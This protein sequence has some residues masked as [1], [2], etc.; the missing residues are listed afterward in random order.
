MLNEFINECNSLIKEVNSFT[1]LDS[2]LNRIGY[3][4]KGRVFK[5]ETEKIITNITTIFRKSNDTQNNNNRVIQ[6]LDALHT[7]LVDKINDC[8][9]ILTDKSIT[10]ESNEEQAVYLKTEECLSE[11]IMTINKISQKLNS[12]KNDIKETN[13]AQ[14]AEEIKIKFQTECLRL[15]T[16]VNGH[17][18]IN[19]ES[20]KRLPVSSQYRDRLIEVINSQIKLSIDRLNHLDT[21]EEVNE[22]QAQLATQLKQLAEIGAAQKDPLLNALANDLKSRNLAIM[23]EKRYLYRIRDLEVMIKKTKA[24]LNEM[25]N[26]IQLKANSLFNVIEN[27]LLIQARTNPVVLQK[28]EALVYTLGSSSSAISD[29]ASCDNLVLKEISKMAGYRN[30]ESDYNQHF[31]KSGQSEEDK[32]AMIAGKSTLIAG[33]LKLIESGNFAKAPLHD[34]DHLLHRH[35][36]EERFNML[37][38]DP[39][40]SAK[41]ALLISFIERESIRLNSSLDT[42]IKTHQNDQKNKTGQIAE[43]LENSRKMIPLFT[44]FALSDH[45][46]LR[47]L[48]NKSKKRDDFSKEL[49]KLKLDSLEKLIIDNLDDYAHHNLNEISN[50]IEKRIHTHWNQFISIPFRQGSGGLG[51]VLGGGVCM[52]LS[53]RFVKTV[54]E[55]PDIKDEDLQCDQIKPED[56]FVQATHGMNVDKKRILIKQKEKMESQPSLPKEINLNLDDNL[57]DQ[58]TEISHESMD[59]EEYLSILPEAFLKRNKLE[60]NLLCNISNILNPKI[61]DEFEKQI[62]DSVIMQKSNGAAL[63]SFQRHI[64]AL[65]VDS[66]KGVFRFYDP[67]FGLY[68]FDNIDDLIA[69]TKDLAIYYGDP[70]H[71]IPTQLIKKTA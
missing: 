18:A 50:P 67:N 38:L 30:L 32:A 10:I 57:F 24:E 16:E 39:L 54:I 55:N 65:H 31:Q 68:K 3:D 6:R 43:Y 4:S 52:G 22:Q 28:V 56:R 35:I 45:I 36:H 9:K 8:N 26:E 48:E 47:G 20:L 1:K 29:P 33:A 46:D 19:I 49:E 70:N 71:M 64:C 14:H 17:L 42:I 53:S 60:P 58:M 34:I 63:I 2:T 44:Y 59:L 7:S 62:K 40:K 61:W 15:Q 25:P 66:A 27:E 11:M 13:L 69:L 5:K 21:L 12:T 37:K 23:N 41:L 51:E